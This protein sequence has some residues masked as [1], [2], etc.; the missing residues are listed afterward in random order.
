MG[1]N[2]RDDDGRDDSWPWNDKWLKSIKDEHDKFFTELKNEGWRLEKELGNDDNTSTSPF[3]AFKKFVDSSFQ[4]FT[5]GFKNFPSNIAELRAKMQREQERLHEE[6]LDISRRWTGS[7]DT[8]DHIQLELLRSTE[9]ERREAFD[10]TTSILAEAQRRNAHVPK[11]KIAALFNDPESM[12]GY[13]DRLASP[14][15]ALGG[16]WYYMPET[17][18]RLPTADSWRW[19]APQPRWLSVDWFKRSP[20]SPIRLEA[21]PDL[22][23]EGE[24]WRAAFEDLMDASLDKP[25]ESRERVGMRALHGKPQSTYHGPGLEW[26]LSLQ[27]RGILPPLLPRAHNDVDSK[28]MLQSSTPGSIIDTIRQHKQDLSLNSEQAKR[29]HTSLYQD[30]SDLMSEIATKSTSDTVAE[31]IEG[32]PPLEGVA[33]YRIQP[34]TEQDLY[35]SP[36][37]WSSI[38][39]P[40]ESQSTPSQTKVFADE[41]TRKFKWETEKYEALTHALKDGDIDAATDVLNDWYDVRGEID[42]FVEDQINRLADLNQAITQ[43]KLPF[44]H[45][46]KQ[47]AYRFLDEL[48]RTDVEK[49]KQH[50]QELDL[51]R[52]LSDDGERSEEE[53]KEF[54]DRLEQERVN[55]DRMV[56][57]KV[58]EQPVVQQKPEVLSALTTTETTRLPDGTITTKVVL[59]KRFADGREETSESVHTAKEDLEQQ[60]Q[61]EDGKTK[62]KGW[63]WQPNTVIG[64]MEHYQSVDSQSF[65][66]FE[67]LSNM[68]TSLPS[69]KLELQNTKMSTITMDPG[70]KDHISNQCERFERFSKIGGTTYQTALPA[71]S[72]DAV[73][74]TVAE[75]DK[76]MLEAERAIQGRMSRLR[77]EVDQF[78]SDVAEHSSIHWYRNISDLTAYESSEFHQI[79]SNMRIHDFDDFAKYLKET[80]PAAAKQV[81]PDHESFSWHFLNKIKTLLD[82]VL[83]SASHPVSFS[84]LATIK[85]KVFVLD[86]PRIPPRRL[87]PRLASVDTELLRM[88]DMHSNMDD[89]DKYWDF[90]S[91]WRL[92]VTSWEDMASDAGS[93]LRVLDPIRKK[94][95]AEIRRRTALAVSRKLP[96]ELAD[97][98]LEHAMAV[99]EVPLEA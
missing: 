90:A 2:G 85:A 67:D 75:I 64:I 69:R 20:Y 32:L 3:T 98:V 16:A 28:S 87:A 38:A 81:R 12:L 44:D 33:P 43:S 31:P 29:W 83:G 52:R 58:E 27:C 19:L 23:L 57:E 61:S 46:Q 68:Y 6:E 70:C 63:F 26:L 24:K 77:R 56:G 15:L 89:R 53:E 96:Q 17:G 97:L 95:E 59:R 51:L 42:W 14:M 60:H 88:M 13:L 73:R 55:L 50:E 4:G 93:L 30:I 22:G 92:L 41:E 78:R 86:R 84:L 7:E 65:D 71:R 74:Q 66:T 72:A 45:P 48:T 62:K 25:M 35:D 34:A 5:D 18:D 82:L 1:A 91:S 39:L 47:E 76:I 21:H 11:A 94:A 40:D 10:A 8:P 80:L 54:I 9:Q 49:F 99:E 37:I 36:H 79:L